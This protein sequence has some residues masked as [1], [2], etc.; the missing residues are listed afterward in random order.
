MSDKA[1]AQT[2][3]GSD[4]AMKPREGPCRDDGQGCPPAT[5]PLQQQRAPGHSV[6]GVAT[7][8]AQAGYGTGSFPGP[9]TAQGHSKNRTLGFCDFLGHC[10]IWFYIVRNQKH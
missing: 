5:S 4:K 9:G 7:W 1:S 3:A 10:E 2:S 8:A 6:G